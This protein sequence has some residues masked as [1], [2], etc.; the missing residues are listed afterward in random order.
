MNYYIEGNSILFYLFQRM[1]FILLR[2]FLYTFCILTFLFSERAL[3]LT[4]E[5]PITKVVFQFLPA[6]TDSAKKWNAGFQD[7]FENNLKPTSNRKFVISTFLQIL[8][9]DVAIDGDTLFADTRES[10]FVE[11][12]EELRVVM[13]DKQ[14]FSS[15]EYDVQKS[16]EFEQ[17]AFVTFVDR[18]TSTL[19]S[20][21][22]N[23]GGIS[24]GSLQLTD[25]D[26]SIFNTSLNA[27]Y[28]YRTENDIGSDVNYSIT[29]DNLLS[30]PLRFTLDGS[31]NTIK[32]SQTFQLMKPLFHRYERWSFGVMY[33][34]ESGSDFIFQEN[35]PLLNSVSL[36]RGTV[37][38]TWNYPESDQ[39][40]V[41]LLYS[42]ENIQRGSPQFQQAFDNT[43][44]FLVGVSSL[45]KNLVSASIVH[46]SLHSF[47]T[48]GGWGTATLGRVFAPNDR[49]MN[50]IGGQA[51]RTVVK[52]GLYIHG[53]VTAGSGFDSRAVALNTYQDFYGLLYGAISDNFMVVSRLHQQKVWNWNSQFR[54]LILDNESGLRG[55]QANQLVGENRAIFN[56]EMRYIPQFS[57]GFLT[58]N[59]TFFYDGGTVFNAVVADAKFYHSVG[60]GLRFHSTT[61]SAE[62]P[63]FRIDGVYNF[64]TKS[65]GVQF[66]VDDIFRFPTA[67]VHLPTVYG[68][69]ND[70]E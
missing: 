48:E 20:T 55:Y 8:P 53:R 27:R 25:N 9:I 52:K 19:Q 38:G 61:E 1:N 2:S 6:S 3:S 47:V 49:S 43:A 30:L 57:L 29:Q 65:L 56:L 36:Q 34:N 41:T 39:F 68:L 21:F 44:R 32:N 31:I 40:L 18:A 15:V 70:L 16:S 60:A 11:D 58:A 22:S 4:E 50:Y 37:W 64:F 10:F 7:I 67:K 42:N 62:R 13:L 28:S 12:L 59:P 51:E 14:L 23:G 5:T 54:Q 63:L 26:F 35:T 69:Q 17:V 46:P 66:S 45:K 24:V 33:Q